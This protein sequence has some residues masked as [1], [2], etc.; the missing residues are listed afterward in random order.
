MV[1]QRECL[2]YARS[3]PWRPK[4]LALSLGDDVIKR[5]IIFNQSQISVELFNGWVIRTSI[6]TSWK[7]TGCSKITNWY[8]NGMTNEI[9]ASIV[10][11]RSTSSCPGWENQDFGTWNTDNCRTNFLFGWICRRQHQLKPQAVHK[12]YKSWFEG[13]CPWQQR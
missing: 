2:A 9:A 3:Y 4:K 10:T 5:N 8:R 13:N 6:K 11:C 1:S 12:A 7:W